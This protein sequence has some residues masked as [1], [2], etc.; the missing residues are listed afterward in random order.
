MQLSLEEFTELSKALLG[1]R[2]NLRNSLAFR[3]VS[4]VVFKVIGIP[5]IA[6]G[7]KRSNVPGTDKLNLAVLSGLVAT[8]P[9]L[10]SSITG[11]M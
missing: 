11:K 5:L 4:G 6:T 10:L 1:N 9:G 8:A 2:K 3:V 7:I